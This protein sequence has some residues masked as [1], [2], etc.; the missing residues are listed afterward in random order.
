MKILEQAILKT[1]LYSDI[2]NFP[3]TTKEIYTRL[4]SVKVSPKQVE[5]VLQSLIKKNKIEQTDNLFY[6]KGR[7]KISALRKK[8]QR[9]A[10]K[11]WRQAE[12]LAKTLAFIPTIIGIFATGTLAVSNTESQ[13]D[14]DLMIITRDNTLWTTRLF[15]TPILDL[16]GKRRKPDSG[17][18]SDLLCL[19]IYLTPKS[20][21]LPKSRRNIYTAYELLQIKPIINKN[22]SYE[23]LLSSNSWILD[24]FPNSAI[25]TSAKTHSQT[26]NPLEKI[27]F[28]LQK[29]YMQ[30]KI[31][32]ESIT[33]GS[34]FFHPR[35]LS[36]DIITKFENRLKKHKIKL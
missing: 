28:A 4:I 10:K 14:I 17:E 21:R 11:K 27:S 23:Q 6:L 26:L 15:I 16:L 8:R 35:N 25:P 29:K 2:F 20:F 13:D 9:I 32:N 22:Q 19:N 24:F 18:I 12:K 5:Q 1:I 34:A 33:R 36:I 3:L 30:R 31:T 7:K